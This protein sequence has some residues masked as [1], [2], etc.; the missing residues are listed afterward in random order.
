MCRD[1]PGVW[2]GLVVCVETLTVRV[3]WVGG[4]CRDP[5]S[6]WHGL[7]SCVQTLTV[8][9][10]RVGGVCRAPHSAWHWLVVCGDPDGGCG[11]GWECHVWRPSGTCCPVSDVMGQCLPGVW[12]LQSVW[13]EHHTYTVLCTL[14]SNMFSVLPVRKLRRGGGVVHPGSSWGVVGLRW[15][16]VVVVA[17]VGPGVL[18]AAVC[19]LGRPL[20]WGAARLAPGQFLVSRGRRHVPCLPGAVPATPVPAGPSVQ[21]GTP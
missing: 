8:R 13:H 11:T 12:G 19:G 3:A 21:P 5:H 16:P 14:D 9:V 17:R 7:V 2:H 20:Q 15:A 18:P 1:P 6:A 4:V 10:A